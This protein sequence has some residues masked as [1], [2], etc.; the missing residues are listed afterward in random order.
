MMCALENTMLGAALLACAAMTAEAGSCLVSGDTTRVPVATA[1]S[2]E[3]PVVLAFCR[4][5]VASVG[6]EGD[7]AMDARFFFRHETMPFWIRLTFPGFA[8][9]FR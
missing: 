5:D 4:A 8:I 9:I 1:S 7:S 3:V 2:S 6:T